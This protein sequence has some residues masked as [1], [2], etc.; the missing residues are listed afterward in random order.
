MNNRTCAT[1]NRQWPYKT[2]LKKAWQG[3]GTV[4]CPYCHTPQYLTPRTRLHAGSYAIM[5]MAIIFIARVFV[6]MTTIQS[7]V[8]ALGIFLVVF[9]VYP[10]TIELT[11]EN[12]ELF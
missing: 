9:L 12:K 7:I 1:C 10:L 4:A 2:A 8:V 11:D 3:K 5:A 6:E